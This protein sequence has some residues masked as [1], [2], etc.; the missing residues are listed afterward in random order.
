MQIFYVPDRSISFQLSVFFVSHPDTLF[1]STKV[2]PV[3]IMGLVLSSMSRRPSNLVRQL[4]IA[5]TE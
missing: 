5:F 4:Y 1:L 3:G 2:L